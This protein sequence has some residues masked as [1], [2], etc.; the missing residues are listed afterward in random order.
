[1]KTLWAIVCCACIL[2]HV[3]V[4]VCVLD[5]VRDCWQIYVKEY[6]ELT[7]CSTSFPPSPST[8]LFVCSLVCFCSGEF[9]LLV[10]T[11]IKNVDSV[12]DNLNAMQ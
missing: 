9:C 2:V 12:M 4:C 3:L 7:H 10:T 1:M 11:H 5:F 6:L 8:V